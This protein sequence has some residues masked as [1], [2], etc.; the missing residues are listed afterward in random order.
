MFEKLFINET[1]KSFYDLQYDLDLD[2][3]SDADTEL[4]CEDDDRFIIQLQDEQLNMK[5]TEEQ[6][7][8]EEQKVVE[9]KIINLL[10]Y[11]SGDEESLFLDDS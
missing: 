3:D 7:D 5:Q 6:K 9:N 8:E 4:E 11:E 1:H 10:C 2:T